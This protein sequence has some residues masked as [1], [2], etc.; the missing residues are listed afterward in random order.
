MRWCLSSVAMELVRWQKTDVAHFKGAS[1]N[2]KKSALQKDVPVV[3]SCADGL[4]RVECKK[5]SQNA[6]EHYWHV[7]CVLAGPDQKGV[8]KDNMVLLSLESAE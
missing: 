3:G 2:K 6:V 1:S 4:Q 8:L 7:V 5:H